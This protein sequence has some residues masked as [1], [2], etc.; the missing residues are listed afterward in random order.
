VIKKLKYNL[1]IFLFKTIYNNKKKL[2]IITIV[3]IS[4]MIIGMGAV[5]I[6]PLLR[7]MLRVD[8][9]DI[10]DFVPQ[11]NTPLF[12]ININHQIDD[13]RLNGS[14]II[15]M[16]ENYFFGSTNDLESIYQNISNA[17]SLACYLES[18]GLI[19][20]NIRP[21]YLR[22]ILL[23]ME[24]NQIPGILGMNSMGMNSHGMN[25]RY[26][27]FTGYSLN[28]AIT[29][30]IDPMDLQRTYLNYRELLDLY[31]E[32]G[33]GI[34]MSSRHIQDI[35]LIG[36]PVCN[37]ENTADGNIL[38]AISGIFCNNCDNLINLNSP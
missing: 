26:V 16:T 10:Q 36:C 24:A 6:P 22:E 12:S 11:R 8:S 20:T 18:R 2:E 30:I 9:I 32:T 13:I 15:Q 14:A 25:P 33:A 29:H 21:L 27:L 17:G 28:M 3:F 37:H 19:V 5:S 31:T 4:L 7:A 34:I 38:W 23:Y 35:S 1:N